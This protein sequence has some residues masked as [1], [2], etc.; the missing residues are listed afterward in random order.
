ML[1][2]FIVPE[3]TETPDVS[4]LRQA[5]KA[6]LPD[7]MVPSA[8]VL[9]DELPL[10]PNGKVD[11]KALPSGDGALQANAGEYVAPQG[12]IETELAGLWARLLQRENVG[13][14]DDFFELGGHSL[15]AAQALARLRD[16]FGIDVSLRDFLEA[17]TVS[18]LAKQIENAQGTGQASSLP[19]L[20]PRPLDQ[21]PTLSFS[22]QAMWFLDQLAP[23]LPTFNITA[24]AKVVGPLDLSALEK[25]LTALV[26]R[27]EVLRTSFVAQAGRPV[28][29]VVD[30]VASRIALIDIARLDGP[31][32]ERELD[33]IVLEESR[34]PFDL[35]R[36]PL[37]RALVV[38]LGPDAHAVLLSMHHIVT[39][40]WSFGVAARA[41]SPKRQRCASCSRCQKPSR[42]GRSPAPGGACVRCCHSSHRPRSSGAATTSSRSRPTNSRWG[43]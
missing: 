18:G 1:V 40:G 26:D 42:T 41:S 36:A 34:T 10:T 39:D 22:Q 43:I 20:R 16:S 7:Y 28:P 32:R 23:G 14:N 33:R 12:P 2:A 25:A 4:A 35:T 11:R 19:P 30:S 38:R 15:F 13:A 5:L 37:A 21:A 6:D 31:E 3:T 27:H 24:A 8:F 17:P 9:L 29:V